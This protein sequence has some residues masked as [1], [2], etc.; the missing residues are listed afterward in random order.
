MRFIKTVFSCMAA[1]ALS[2]S[3]AQAGVIPGSLSET[4]V[5]SRTGGQNFAAYS[6][7]SIVNN[8]WTNSTAKSTAPG[9]TAGIGSRFNSASF[10][11]GQDVW[12]Q[13]APTL[14]TAGGVYDVY[15]TVTNGSGAIT[16]TSN[17][18][19]TGGT[20]LPA[21]TTAFGTVESANKW[22]LV[23]RLT[24]NAGVNNPTVRFHETAHNNRLY[25]D[26]VLFAEVDPIPEP[27]SSALLVL[28]SLGLIAGRRRF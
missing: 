26:A 5:E 10:I 1:L 3:A 11:G 4:M 8:T 20:G 16:A 23:G 28:A 2:G 12:F 22:G 13:V 21:S 15:V 19:A 6:E 14:P 9:V 7:M 17:I 24:L 18:T 27:A 25:A